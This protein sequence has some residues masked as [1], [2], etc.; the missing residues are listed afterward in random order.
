MKKVLLFSLIMLLVLSFIYGCGKEEPAT[1]KVP[2][3]VQEAEMMDTTAMDSAADAGA[4]VMDS[5]AVE[6]DSM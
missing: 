4:E 2:A 5:M 1:D 3:D 6:K